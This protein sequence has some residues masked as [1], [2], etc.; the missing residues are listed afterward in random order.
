MTTLPSQ[1]RLVIH[2]DIDDYLPVL[3]TSVVSFEE[4]IKYC[5]N[6]ILEEDFANVFNLKIKYKFIQNVEITITNTEE[7]RDYFSRTTHPK[8]YLY[9]YVSVFY[10]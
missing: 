6:N 5:E 9:T 1:K 4:I 10:L 3:D 7:L 8:L 2:Y